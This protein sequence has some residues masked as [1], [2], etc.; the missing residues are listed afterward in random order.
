M[1]SRELYESVIGEVC[2]M[3][4]SSVIAHLTHFQGE[5]RLDFSEEY[6]QTCDTDRLRHWLV[7]AIWRCRMKTMTA[8]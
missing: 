5:I 2:E 1:S 7:A 4:R 6:L 3:D 8:A